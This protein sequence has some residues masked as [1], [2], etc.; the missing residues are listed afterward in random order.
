MTDFEQLKQQ[1]EQ[2]VRTGMTESK[3][4]QLISQAGRI[5]INP[6][7]LVMLIKNAELELKF[8]TG[9][10]NNDYPTD[11]GSGFMMEPESPGSGFIVENDPYAPK[12]SEGTQALVAE[13]APAP[14]STPDASEFT[15]IKKLDEQGAMSDVYSALHLGR[16]KVII[17]RIKPQYRYNSQY[18]DLFYKEFDTGYSLEN[19][20]V[21]H[22]YGKGEDAEGPY[23]YMEY[24]DGRTLADYLKEGHE[25]K[26]PQ[27]TRIVLQI[28]EALSY[29]HSKQVF[30][31]DLKPANI[32]LT[33]KGDN[34]KIIDFGL[35]ADDTI[36]DNLKNA[37]TP[38][39]AAPEL[40]NN[41]KT[42]DQRTD[43]YSLG[44][45]ILE[46]FTGSPDRKRLAQI[47]NQVFREI[48]DRAT[49]ANPH[50]RFHSCDEIISL[51]KRE[52]SALATASSPI[53]KWL[54]DRIKEYAADGFIS[55]NERI[56]LDQEIAKTGADK[57]I[58]D[59]IINDEIEKAILKKRK[60]EEERRRNTKV[61][62]AETNNTEDGNSMRKVFK[63]LLWIILCLIIIWGG[64][65]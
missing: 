28:A 19:P 35:A 52:T 18:I 32:M 16:R 11:L 25:L 24:V 40:F 37:G 54:E 6:G 36:V 41:A 15:E 39:Y 7:Q 26:T 56:V 60:E 51:L 53:P 44:M 12:D 62:V 63:I 49:M 43:I 20:G 2:Y 64:I 59:A 8:A 50:D 55:R 58:V 14:T 21:V 27:I 13:D 4:Q 57:K 3:R 61:L 23:Y 46:I 47:N 34:V 5:G 17:K 65:K 48:A 33:Y 10:S 30:H 31:R 9:V 42:A 45:I 1:I 22:F 38:K 29:M